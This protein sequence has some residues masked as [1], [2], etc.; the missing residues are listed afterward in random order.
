KPV[1]ENNKAVQELFGFSKNSEE[2]IDG[3]RGR[4]IIEDTYLPNE[5]GAEKV[6]SHTSIDRFTN[7]TIDGALFQEKVSFFQDVITIPIWVKEK[8]FENE[9]VKEAFLLSLEDLKN[10]RLSL[11]GSAS[12]GHGVFEEIKS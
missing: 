12:K 7:G 3:L 11:G 8:A 4:V 2:E 6:F 5:G 1:G 9:Q 10:G